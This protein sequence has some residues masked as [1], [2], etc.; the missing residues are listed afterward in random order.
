MSRAD[1]TLRF[2]RLRFLGSHLVFGG[3]LGFALALS[4]LMSFLPT[5]WEHSILRTQPYSSASFWIMMVS[6]VIDSVLTYLSSR[7]CRNISCSSSKSVTCISKT[8][9][10][11]RS[12]EA[13]VINRLIFQFFLIRFYT[14]DEVH[15][16]Q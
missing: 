13:A 1:N 16:A 12:L 8:A 6:L 5:I 2:I 3:S 10:K 7:S 9:N 11:Q 15:S 14:V 4:F